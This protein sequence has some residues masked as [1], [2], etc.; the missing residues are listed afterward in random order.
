MKKSIVLFLLS[1]LTVTACFSQ[2]TYPSILND[3]LIVITN[4][5]LKQTNLLF[6]DRERLIK[7]NSELKFQIDNYNSILDNY[8]Y[9]DTIKSNQI[10]LLKT[11]LNDYNNIINNQSIKIDKLNKSN[12]VLKGISIGGIVISIS[13]IALLCLN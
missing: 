12:K 7:E 10:D 8:K 9:T 4:K 13:L 5:Q 2:T 6:L 3:S 1:L 11:N